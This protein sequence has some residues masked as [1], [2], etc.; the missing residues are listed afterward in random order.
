MEKVA[1]AATPFPLLH[2]I[3]GNESFAFRRSTVTVPPPPFCDPTET[4]IGPWITSPVS[5]P[6]FFRALSSSCI[7]TEFRAALPSS[8]CTRATSALTPSILALPDTSATAE[9]ELAVTFTL[10]EENDR[11]AILPR[12]LPFWT[13]DFR[14][15]DLV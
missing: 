13:E 6:S 8:G 15:Q 2:P 7:V 14:V 3:Q 10:A 11:P 4:A 1:V 5:I 9:A 12:E